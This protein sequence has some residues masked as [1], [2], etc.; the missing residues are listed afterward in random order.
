MKYVAL[1]EAAKIDRIV[2]SDEECRTFPYVGLEHIEKDVGHFVA[3][4]ERKPETLLATKFRFTPRHVLYGK[5]RPYLNKAAL[6]SFDG[7]CTTEILPILP[8]EG[9][10]DRTYLWALLLTPA[11]VEWASSNVSGANLPRL[12]PQLLGQYRI[13]LPPLPEQQ[14]IAAVLSRADRLRRLRRT[15][16]ELSDTYLQSVFLE[17]FGDPVSNPR[18]WDL[19]ELG[20]ACTEMYRYP[21]FYGFKYI[22]TGVPVAR[23]GNILPQGFLDPDLSAYVFIDPEISE[24]FPR[25]VLELQDI[26]MAVRGDGS[27]A[28][29]IGLVNSSNLAGANISPNLLRFKANEEVL[30]PLYLFN[31][32]TCEGG[33][34]LLGRH[35]TRT[36]KRTI[37]ARDIKRIKIPS[38]PLPLQQ[39]FAA[40]VHQFERLRAQQQEA[41]RQA[42]HLFQAL[43]ERA[44]R[45]ARSLGE[46]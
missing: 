43:L 12:A 31:L 15:A 7:V 16:R 38:P 45:S 25:T 22:E 33:Q 17:M 4:F 36:A 30:N 35:V 27:T 24:R 1:N 19:V 32:M 40:I 37:T 26:L 6:P 39:Q 14:R 29:R 44:F 23:I 10:L 34:R 42:E 21:T 20:D 11:F 8:I 28:T 13:P 41:E 2:A 46:M 3:E 5:L 18:G 9:K